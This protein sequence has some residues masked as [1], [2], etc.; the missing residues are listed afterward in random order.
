[1]IDWFGENISWIFSGVG[2][3]LIVFVYRLFT[4]KKAGDISELKELHKEEAKRR[5]EQLDELEKA[6][7]KV[8]KNTDINVEV[9]SVEIMIL[10]RPGVGKTQI[11]WTQQ[12]KNTIPSA[13]IEKT[14]E[15]FVHASSINQVNY[16]FHFIVPDI[17]GDNIFLG[18]VN[19]ELLT[20]NPVG[21]VF[22]VDHNKGLV[23][24]ISEDRISEHLNAIYSVLGPLA[25]KGRSK[26][27]IVLFL[28]NKEDVWG[29]KYSFE[30][31]ERKF[32]KHIQLFEEVGLEVMV[33]S[34][35]AKTGANINQALHSIE[36]KII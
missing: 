22:I 9:K 32:S 5:K 16:M 35:S 24:E 2:I 21:L 28:I 31:M 14:S 20:R 8:R 7:Q 3:T 29:K 10:G 26:A 34:I 15:S 23:P 25:N 6:K 36:Q 19:E 12:G 33:K 4:N 18:E 17:G 30:E 27:R 11:I 13:T 1:M